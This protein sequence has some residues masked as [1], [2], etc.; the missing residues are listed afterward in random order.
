MLPEGNGF[1]KMLRR[2]N[3]AKEDFPNLPTIAGEA[4]RREIL[5]SD[6]SKVLRYVRESWM[7][8]PQK[9]FEKPIS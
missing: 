5:Y 9:I 3:K 8:K 7:N 1:W 6:I 4:L 2:S